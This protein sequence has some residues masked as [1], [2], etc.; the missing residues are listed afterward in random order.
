[1]KKFH[2]NIW[3]GTL[4]EC[5][6]EF[7]SLIDFEHVEMPRVDY[8]AVVNEYVDTA[9]EAYRE[10]IGWFGFKNVAKEFDCDTITLLFAHYGGGGIK[11]LELTGEDPET[12]KKEIMSKITESTDAVG[13]GRFEADDYTV[14]EL[15]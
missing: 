9:Y 3:Y 11:S 7:Y 5:V 2:E 10:A 4:R 13:F 14:F 8:A 1:M 6:N 12:E 15:E